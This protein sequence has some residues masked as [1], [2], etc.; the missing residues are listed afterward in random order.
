MPVEKALMEF[1][2]PV[3]GEDITAIGGHYTLTKED[4]LIHAGREVLYLIGYGSVDTSC[5][6]VGGC[7]YALVPG[8]V[9]SYRSHKH[10]ENSRDVSL[11]EP[12]EVESLAALAAELKALEG[13][14][15]VQFFTAQDGRKVLY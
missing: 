9:V 13:V 11:I 1:V 6:G 8:Y 2:H 7:I 12:V 4:R 14:T 15:Q 10:P 3:L 5:C